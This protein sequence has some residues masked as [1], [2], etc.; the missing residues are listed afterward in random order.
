[1][2]TNHY[3]TSEAWK[4][5][6]SLQQVAYKHH[7]YSVKDLKKIKKYRRVW[8]RILKVTNLQPSSRIFEL[9]CGGGFQ[10][11]ALAVNG[12]EVYGIDV[13]QDV[14]GRAKNYLKEISS[15]QSIKATVEVADIF[16]YQDSNMYDMCFHFGVVEH[17]LE[18]PQR[19]IIWN[20]LYDLTKPG[21]WIV[22]VVPCGLH[23]MRKMVR[24][25]GLGGYEVPEIDYSCYSHRQEFEDLNLSP[26]YTLTHNYFSFLFTHP[27]ELVSKLIAPSLFITGNTLLPYLPIPEKVK[28][29]YAQTIIVIGKK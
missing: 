5:A 14:A 18:L 26:I 27:S 6:L 4:Q 24:E 1:M 12:F 7:C 11:G 22:S 21:G 29:R 10:L 28:E 3:E 16:K 23:F 13:S 15:F 8:Q 17:F 9:G 2:N 25:K 19:Q 20:K